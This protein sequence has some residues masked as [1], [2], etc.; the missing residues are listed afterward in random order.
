VTERPGDGD[1]ESYPCP[2]NLVR[3]S[4]RISARMTRPC[5][6][7]GQFNVPFFAS[8]RSQFFYFLITFL[9]LGWHSTR[10]RFAF[11]DLVWKG[12]PDVTRAEGGCCQDQGSALR[13][14]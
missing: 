14:V 4:R 9:S 11:A 7:K 6:L 2:K 1:H 13:G 3:M 10:E 8:E 12:A 5:T